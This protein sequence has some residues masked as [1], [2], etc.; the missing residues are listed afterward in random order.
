MKFLRLLIL[1]VA[2]TFFY[3]G[4]V[5]LDS[6]RAA[7]FVII[8]SNDVLG[9]LELCGCDSEQLGG[10]ARKTTLIKTLK[11]EG[12]PVL[13]IDSGNLFFREKPA[14]KIEENEFLLKSEYIL[15]AYKQTGC[16][17]L[18]V[19]ETDLFLGIA[20]LKNLKSKAPFPFVSANLQDKTSKALLFE[21]FIIKEIAGVSVGIT[22]LFSEQ[23]SVEPSVAVQDPVESAKRIVAKLRPQCTVIIVL[24]NLG[25]ESDR[26]LARAIP[27]IDIIIGGRATVRMA[28]PAKEGKTFIVQAYTRGQYL[29]KLEVQ[30]NTAAAGSRVSMRNYL[31]P[32]GDRIANDTAVASLA[33]EYK[34]RLI[35]MNRQEF[36]KER[37]NGK[38]N[39]ATGDMLYAGAEKCGS[40]HQPQY[41]NWQNTRHAYAYETL[42]KNCNNFDIE[43]LPCHTTGFKEPGGFTVNQGDDSAFV[44]VQCESCHGP[45]KKHIGKGDIVRDAGEGMCRQCHDEKNSPRFNYTEYLPIVKCPVTSK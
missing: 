11:N 45:G 17:A 5:P 4:G 29:G 9:E 20:H 33:K 44:H 13:V 16:D 22:G 19:G 15:E 43:C 42:M 27:D 2:G 10:L 35:A 12:R 23:C 14:S 25:L 21:P 7:P 1:V 39:Q 6:L 28:E 41:D 31:I 24:S 26:K 3:A 40:C 30:A 8:Y 34:T 38:K 32:L 36:F 18:N 37:L